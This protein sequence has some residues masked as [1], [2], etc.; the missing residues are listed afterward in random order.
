MLESMATI[1]QWI[2]TNPHDAVLALLVGLVGLATGL[3][4]RHIILDDAM[5]TFRVAENLAYG[6]GFVYNAGERVQVTTTPLYALVLVPGI[7][8]LGSA[9]AAALGLNIGLAALIPVLAY[10]TGRRLA[11]R[12]TGVAGALLLSLSPF[13][14][15]AFSMESYLYVALILASV[16]AYAAGRLQ[17]AG[18]LAGVTALVRGDAALLAACMLGYDVLAQRRL[19]RRLIIPAVAIPAGWYLFALLYYG[20]PFPA[21]LSAKTAQGEINW[22]GHRFLDG[23]YD[24]LREWTELGEHLVFYLFPALWLVGLGRALRVERPWLIL[25]GRDILYVTAFAGLAVPA[26]EWYYAPLMP[27]AALLVGRGIQAIAGVVAGAARPK[28]RGMAATAAAGVGL[29]VLLA[30]I[31]PISAEI[32]GQHPDWKARIYPPA[33]RWIAQNTSPS[34]NLATIDIGHLGYWSGRQII[35]IV[36]LAQPDV[37]AHIAGG[38]FGYAIRHYRPDMV[39][40]SYLWLPEVQQTGWFKEAYVPRRYFTYNSYDL[41]LV[42]FSRRQGVKV[43]SPVIP[44]LEI[45]QVYNTCYQNSAAGRLTE[46]C[47]EAKQHLEARFPDTIRPEQI[48]P[49]NVDFNRQITL[50][51]YF[52]SQPLVAGD[53]LNLTLFWQANTPVNVDFTVFVQVMDSGNTIV[54][55]N[56][57]KPQN[58]F[59]PTP[60]WQPGEQVLD[61]HVVYLPPDLPPGQYD[62]LVG[63]YEADSGQRL[64]I[65]D[66]A[67]VFKSDH[68]RIPGVTVQPPKS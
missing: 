55:Q 44:P 5:I 27:G 68:V 28:Y 35:D 3:W 4:A 56:D 14:V 49:L 52:L 47:L 26:A 60:Y 8:L 6:Q 9:P 34:A 7:W 53:L 1:K 45:E 41:P 13:L 37:A 50:T 36:G 62:L 40:I 30:A 2:K 16:D 32:V 17:L 33:A 20:S 38:D 12:V 57:T 66:E 10:D 65:L 19:R 25:V 24:Y 29:V 21:T 54:A 23:L 43:Q 39:L 63:L 42:L 31:F 59:Y 51:G 11:G 61:S 58:G 46:P 64:Q 15:M 22:L 18:V 67:G 48:Q